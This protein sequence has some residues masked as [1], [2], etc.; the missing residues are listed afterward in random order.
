MNSETIA[1]RPWPI[2]ERH[3]SQQQSALIQRLLKR[4]DFLEEKIQMMQQLG[5]QAVEEADDAAIDL[6]KIVDRIDAVDDEFTI[7]RNLM[8]DAADELRSSP[9]VHD[10]A[11]LALEILEDADKKT[12]LPALSELRAIRDKTKEVEDDLRSGT[13]AEDFEYLA[14]EE[15]N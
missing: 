12:A 11:E 14:N 10:K 15:E 9:R 2:I 8:D 1:Y 3:A 6:D 4:I 7:M 5:E 13:A